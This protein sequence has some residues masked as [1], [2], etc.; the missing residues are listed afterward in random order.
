LRAA[1]D[2]ISDLEFEL[3]RHE[4][5]ARERRAAAATDWSVYDRIDA[6]TTR[7]EREL[8]MASPAYQKYQAWRRATGMLEKGDW[9][10]P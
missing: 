6:E 4:E 9:R 1:R 5:A 3:E 10:A 2:R 8:F 7:R